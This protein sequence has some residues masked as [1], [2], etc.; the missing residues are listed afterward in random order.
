MNLF[1]RDIREIL[2]NE[3]NSNLNDVSLSENATEL[4]NEKCNCDVL[5]NFLK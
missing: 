5:A 2:A 4:L 1:R 3:F